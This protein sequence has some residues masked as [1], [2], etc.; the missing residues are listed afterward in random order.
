MEGAKVIQGGGNERLEASSS[1]PRPSPASP[2]RKVAATELLGTLLEVALGRPRHV[3]A[4]TRS[5]LRAPALVGQA[6]RGSGGLP[7]RL[8]PC[9]SD[10][11]GPELAYDHRPHSGPRT[12]THRCPA[13][14]PRQCRTGTRSGVRWRARAL[15]GRRQLAADRASAAR[16]HTGA[17]THQGGNRRHPRHGARGTELL[18][19]GFLGRLANAHRGTAAAVRQRPARKP[20]GWWSLRRATSRAGLWSTEGRT[21]DGNQTCCLSASS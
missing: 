12:H 21:E 14:C 19:A 15:G 10:Q 4:A 16:W 18:A 13:N 5:R 3:G 8:A 11:D 6:R 2:T 7:E 17:A 9:G 20:I 1:R